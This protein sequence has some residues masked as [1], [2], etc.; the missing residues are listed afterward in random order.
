M[1][2]LGKEILKNAEKLGI[3]SLNTFQ[4]QGLSKILSNKNTFLMGEPGIGK[5]STFLFGISSIVSLTPCER[6][7]NFTISNLFTKSLKPVFKSRPHG[8]LIILQSFDKLFE[9]YKK[10]RILAPWLNIKRTESSL[11][12]FIGGFILRPDSNSDSDE[13]INEG[14]INSIQGVEWPWTDI[15][16]ST[17]D[18]L[19]KFMELRQ[20]LNM[21]GINPAL[22]VIDEL[23]LLLQ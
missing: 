10:M 2:L 5:T 3:S 7:S 1:S 18:S 21:S 22:I 23:D 11:S 15:L 16:L 19:I 20:G 6:P 14:F 9:V 13:I 4:T 17:P 12:H 8:S